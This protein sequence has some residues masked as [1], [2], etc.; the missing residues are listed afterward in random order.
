MRCVEILISRWGFGTLTKSKL[1]LERGD[2]PSAK[3][4]S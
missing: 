4:E 3:K 1:N 2:M